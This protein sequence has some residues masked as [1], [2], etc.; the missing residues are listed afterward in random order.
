MNNFSEFLDHLKK[1]KEIYLLVFFFGSTI[2]TIYAGYMNIQNSILANTKKVEIT[3]VLMLKSIVREVEKS[4][5]LS[6]LE[7]DEYI[8]NYSTLFDLK[9]KH[10]LISVKANWMPIKLKDCR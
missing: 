4:K 9:I 1:L 3:Q 8:L 7:Y 2:I 10:K 5:C 6:P